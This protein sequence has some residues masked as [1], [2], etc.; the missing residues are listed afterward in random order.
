MEKQPGYIRVT[1]SLFGNTHLRQRSSMGVGDINSAD[2]WLLKTGECL[3]KI[4]CCLERCSRVRLASMNWPGSVDI[5]N[6]WMSLCIFQ[7]LLQYFV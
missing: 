4:V 2:S 7:M 5:A 6:E 3:Y 1:H